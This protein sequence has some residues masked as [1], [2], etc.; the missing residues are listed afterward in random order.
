MLPTHDDIVNNQFSSWVKTISFQKK[1]HI[2]NQRKKNTTHWIKYK[3]YS[4]PIQNI[5]VDLYKGWL[6]MYRDNVYLLAVVIWWRDRGLPFGAELSASICSGEYHKPNMP[7]FPQPNWRGKIAFRDLLEKKM[8]NS[9]IM[10]SMNSE[11]NPRE[12]WYN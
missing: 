4:R 8:I 10:K 6:E 11:V 1:N 2:R 5:I 7:V 12:Y 9:M 3:I